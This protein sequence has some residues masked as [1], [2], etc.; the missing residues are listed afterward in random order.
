MIVDLTYMGDRKRKGSRSSENNNSQSK[1]CSD[2][3]NL[4]DLNKEME[5]EM[6]QLS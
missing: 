5:D 6:E 2:I 1:M 4:K 3:I